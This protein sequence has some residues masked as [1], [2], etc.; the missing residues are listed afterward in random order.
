MTLSGWARLWIAAAMLAQAG[1]VPDEHPAVTRDRG[2]VAN[3]E[4]ACESY[5]A[6]VRK[7]WEISSTDP[8][9]RREWEAIDAMRR[10]CSDLQKS[11]FSDP[12]R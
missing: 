2:R 1:C 10:A 12:D 9:L 5:L 3:M 8:Q 4:R 6:N 7:G 11:L